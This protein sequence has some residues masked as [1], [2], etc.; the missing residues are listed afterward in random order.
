LQL[1]EDLEQIKEHNADK[2]GRKAVTPREKVIEQTGRSPD[3]SSCLMMIMYFILVPPPKTTK[4]RG[5]M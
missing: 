1:I 3:Y 2:D 4:A 5:L